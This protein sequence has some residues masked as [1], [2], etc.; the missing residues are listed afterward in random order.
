MT[1]LIFLLI[2]AILGTFAL[3]FGFIGMVVIFLLAL[4]LVGWNKAK[5]IFKRIP[6]QRTP[7]RSNKKDGGSDLLSFIGRPEFPK[8][9]T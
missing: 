4:P 8:N 9:R 1:K 2:K 3:V 7:S 6:K 5:Y